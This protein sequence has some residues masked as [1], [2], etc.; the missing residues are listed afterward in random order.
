MK[1]MAVNLFTLLTSDGELFSFSATE[2]YVKF[3]IYDNK[4]AYIC[5]LDHNCNGSTF[6]QYFDNV[7]EFEAACLLRIQEA[8][9]GL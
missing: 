4:P 7:G 9:H 8:R 6:N 2:N 1:T 3:F 5:M